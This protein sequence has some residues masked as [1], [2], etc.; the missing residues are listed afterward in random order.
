MA[1][2][3]QEQREQDRQ[4]LKRQVQGQPGIGA[5]VIDLDSH[6]RDRQR[7]QATASAEALDEPPGW[8]LRSPAYRAVENLAPWA[9]IADGGSFAALLDDPVDAHLILTRFPPHALARSFCGGP[10]LRQVGLAITREPRRIKARVWVGGYG[11]QDEGI[12]VVAVYARF[13]GAPSDAEA[14]AG[15]HPT[16]WAW[17]AGRL[18][19]DGEQPRW[20]EPDEITRDSTD[21]S[22]PGTWWRL[23]WGPSR[24]PYAQ[25]PPAGVG[26][27]PVCRP[28]A[29]PSP[30]PDRPGRREQRGRR[31]PE[32]S[33]DAPGG[34]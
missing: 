34:S 24:A 20:P 7:R 9:G 31:D 10:T 13:E 4:E 12:S 5:P 14:R 6:R 16:L 26:S 2:G 22:E 3:Q 28:K 23:R 17:V 19:Y 32:G 30:K 29:V 1:S 21:V 11:A 8:L 25:Q 27:I 33:S 18:G 15:Q